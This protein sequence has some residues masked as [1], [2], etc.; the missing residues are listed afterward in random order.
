MGSCLSPSSK[1]SRAGKVGRSQLGAG[2]M[3]GTSETYT[4]NAMAGEG[5]EEGWISSGY[6]QTC[7]SFRDPGVPV[8]RSPF[9]LFGAGRARIGVGMLGD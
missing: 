5:V 3:A 1:G 6:K 4:Q 7:F 2:A 8:T 9:A